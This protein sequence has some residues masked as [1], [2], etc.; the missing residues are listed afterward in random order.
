MELKLTEKTTNL[1]TW[2]N[3]NKEIILEDVPIYILEDTGE[4]LVTLTDTIRA[5]ERRIAKKYN[6][7]IPNIFELALL[8]ADVKQ[9][10]KGI[11]QQFRFNKMLFY[12]GKKL[13]EEYGENVLIFDEMNKAKDGPIPN[14]LKEDMKKLHKEGIFDVFLVK[15]G[16]KI[17]GSKKDWD[18]KNWITIE[19]VLTNKGEDLA[20]KIWSELDPEMRE[21]ILEVKEKL[22]YMKTAK[23]RKK[24]H[25]AYPEYRKIYTQEDKENFVYLL[26]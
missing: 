4:E 13:E 1:E 21:I 18:T 15:K 9:R 8:Y 11:K 3:Q 16:K 12:V 10:T 24:V 20:Q 14:H 7:S 22:Y 6:I 25:K 2:D 23:L 17:S 5:D 26:K 19:C